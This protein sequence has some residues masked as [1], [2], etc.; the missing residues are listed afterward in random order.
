[1]VRLFKAI[2]TLIGD[3]NQLFSLLSILGEN[4]DAVIHAYCDGKLQRL[5]DLGK[6][7]LDSTAQRERLRR[8]GLREEQCEFI[9]AD[10]ESGVGSA[11]GFLQGSRSSAQYIITARMA[12][13]VIYFLE[14]VQVKGNQSKRLAIAP[15]AIEFFFKRFSEEPAVMET[16]QG[17][18]HGIEFQPLQ[19][20]ILDEDGNT[21]KTGGR[22][23]IREC[24]FQGNLTTDEISEL[25]ASR[26]HLIPNFYTLS[27]AQI[28][29]SDRT[30]ISLEK[31]AARRQIEALERVC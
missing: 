17:I 12:V 28:E 3:A 25:A 15:S 10:T 7:R 6:Y 29:V 18:G 20:V 26:E 14:A 21:K 1:V 31:L 23:D 5:E 2:E 16:G 9:A 11:Q 8:I 19:L 4:R 30:K 27:F 22:K 24:G 13:L